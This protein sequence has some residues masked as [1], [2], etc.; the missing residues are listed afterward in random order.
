MGIIFVVVG[1]MDQYIKITVLKEPAK[2]PQA[3]LVKVCPTE[4]E[5]KKKERIKLRV[6]MVNIRYT[7]YS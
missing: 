2:L 6:I 4:L 7:K 3:K 1:S 5:K